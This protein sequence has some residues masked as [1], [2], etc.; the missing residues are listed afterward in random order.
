MRDDVILLKSFDTSTRQ[1]TTPGNDIYALLTGVE[2]VSVV[3]GWV[4][5][6]IFFLF[7]LGSII[8]LAPPTHAFTR[9]SSFIYCKLY[10]QSKI[11]YYVW[12]TCNM[13]RYKF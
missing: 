9:F 1:T 4:F 2:G 8:T 12:A 10:F 3:A 11:L 5:Y 13:F 6:F 7:T